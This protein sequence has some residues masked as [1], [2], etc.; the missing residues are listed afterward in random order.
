MLYYLAVAV[1]TGIAWERCSLAGN[2]EGRT[3]RLIGDRRAAADDHVPLCVTEYSDSSFAESQFFTDG[4]FLFHDDIFKWL[5]NGVPKPRKP[6]GFV[7]L[8]DVVYRLPSAYP[9][10]STQGSPGTCT[11]WQVALLKAGF[12]LMEIFFFKV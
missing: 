7:R 6:R 9:W 11:V 1:F 5:K 3:I 2:D 4:D 8:I 10:Q 12:L